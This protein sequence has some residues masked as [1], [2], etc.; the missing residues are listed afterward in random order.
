M[1]PWGLA[2]EGS[3]RAKGQ[4][5]HRSRR[6]ERLLGMAV[7]FSPPCGADSPASCRVIFICFLFVP[8]TSWLQP[9]PPRN[10]TAG[11]MPGADPLLL[12]PGPALWICKLRP[13]W[14]PDPWLSWP[15]EGPELGSDFSLLRASPEAWPLLGGRWEPPGLSGG[16]GA[17][18]AS[19]GNSLISVPF[20]SLRFLGGQDWAGLSPRAR[21]KCR[22]LGRAAGPFHP[23]GA[24]WR[25]GC[26]LSPALLTLGSGVSSVQWGPRGAC[27]V[28]G[29]G[30]GSQHTVTVTER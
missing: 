17:R 7:P 25:R 5:W 14:G 4:D 28:A 11:T 19:W 18:A 24:A 21:A 6:P 12:P 26:G 15:D 10:R 13:P 29:C 20:R 2:G 22:R 8:G 3:C 30:R 23:L 9:A 1:E 16:A 27:G